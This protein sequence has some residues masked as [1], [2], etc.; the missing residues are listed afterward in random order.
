MARWEAEQ[1]AHG[2]PQA[3]RRGVD[4]DRSATAGDAAGWNLTEP[5]MQ[6]A[7]FTRMVTI[8]YPVGRGDALNRGLHLVAWP[9]GSKGETDLSIAVDKLRSTWRGGLA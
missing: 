4:G 2:E 3:S 5:T 6:A 8:K 9:T 7:V 1:G